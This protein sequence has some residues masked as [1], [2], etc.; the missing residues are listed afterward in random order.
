MLW[1]ILISSLSLSHVSKKGHTLTLSDISN[2]LHLPVNNCESTDSE[3][4][5]IKML[6]FVN[7]VRLDLNSSYERYNKFSQILL[8]K[9]VSLL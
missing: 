3:Y 1:W 4:E 7:Y 5:I 2:V 6:D 9:H 8:T